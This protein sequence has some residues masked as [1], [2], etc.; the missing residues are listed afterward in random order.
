A[1]TTDV[2]DNEIAAYDILTG[3]EGTYTNNEFDAHVLTLSGLGHEYDD[4]QIGLGGHLEFRG[5]NQVFSNNTVLMPGGF[6]VRSQ[7]KIEISNNDFTLTG[8]PVDGYAF[9]FRPNGGALDI[10]FTGNTSTGINQL[11]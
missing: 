5:R 6:Q 10:E 2:Q 11:F 4:N 7:L 3:G 8:H 9:Y 1:L